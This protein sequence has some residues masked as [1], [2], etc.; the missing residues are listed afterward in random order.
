M[1]Q[2][3]CYEMSVVMINVVMTTTVFM[4]F[5]VSKLML[6]YMKIIE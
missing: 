4:N 6:G 2:V 3:C 1:L 5:G